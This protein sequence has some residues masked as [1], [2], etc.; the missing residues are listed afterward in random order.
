MSCHSHTW[1]HCLLKQRS[2]P[3]KM[4]ISTTALTYG[5]TAG[6]LP[7]FR[8]HIPLIILE[9][10]NRVFLFSLFGTEL[11]W[12]ISIWFGLLIIH[13]RVQPKLFLQCCLVLSR[14][15]AI[16]SMRRWYARHEFF[17]LSYTPFL[18]LY[19]NLEWPAA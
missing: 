15:R 7:F 2:L 11:V 1:S 14:L 19:T 12:C 13:P 18:L 10:W 9:N 8:Y 5:L 17:S 3:L 6:S 4:Y 16:V